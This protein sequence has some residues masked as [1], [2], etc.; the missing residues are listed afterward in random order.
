MPLTTADVRVSR[1]SRKMIPSLDCCKLPEECLLPRI[2]VNR[3]RHDPMS[4]ARGTDAA[5]LLELWLMFSAESV[6]W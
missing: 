5:E 6:R 3:K 4:I 2:L 1:S